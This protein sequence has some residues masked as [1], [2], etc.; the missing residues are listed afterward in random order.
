MANLTLRLVK[1]APL[2]NAEVDANFNNLN[3]AKYE[4]GD[5]PDFVDTT[6]D[7]L[8]LDTTATI[9]PTQGQMTWSDDDRTAVLGLNGLALPVGQEELLFVRNTTASPIA[10]GTVVMATGTIGA[11]SR[12]TAAPMDGTNVANAKFLIGIAAETIAAGTDG[13]VANFGKVRGFDTSAFAAGSVLWVSTTTAGAL[14]TTEPT[15]GLKLPIAFVVTSHASVGAIFVRMTTGVKFS[16]AHD[17]TFTSLAN[18]DV[19]IYNSGVWENKTQANLFPSQTSQSGKFLTTNGTSISWANVPSPNNGTLTLGVSGTGLSGSATF[20]ADQS[21]NSTF[22]VTSNATNANTA[23]AIVARDGSGNFSAGTI[24]AALSGNA[25]TA[26][27]LQTARTI[28]GTSFNGSA[29]I[30]ITANTP[31]S[32]TFNNGG[33]G[34]ASGTTFNGGSAVTVSYNTVG[35]PSTTGANASGSWGISITGNAATATS[36]TSATTAT[37]ANNVAIAADTTSTGSFFVPYASA[38]TG[39]V[40]M[41]GTRLTVQPSTGNFTAVGTVTANSDERIK[42]D[43]S[44]LPQD[45]IERLTQV[46]VGTY[47]RTDT[48]ARQAGSSA[49]DWQNLLPEVVTA[50]ED[51][52]GTLSLAYGNAALVAAIELSKIVVE[53]KAE[54]QSLKAQ[55]KG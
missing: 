13:F 33:A 23:G 52:Q 45:F 39:N 8:S 9:T 49:Q 16:E 46:K 30:T 31:N 19:L 28:N 5:S 53:L 1:N 29:N 25:T 43:W 32:V 2:T 26:T 54:V 51:E 41:R 35:A 15:S 48:G 11:S 27:T 17:A 22:T 21:G 50:A 55:L 10:K 7:V 20:T 24:T 4:A 37:N 38:T 34:A 6:T 42:T 44:D 36:A 18:G 40:A 14:T 3:T 47:T 12:I